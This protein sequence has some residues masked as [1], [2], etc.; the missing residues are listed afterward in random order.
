MY[1][2]REAK[3]RRDYIA[4]PESKNLTYLTFW[5]AQ[6]KEFR[7]LAFHFLVLK[8]KENKKE[9]LQIFLK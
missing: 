9:T 3:E 1:I 2:S 6:N 4:W 7:G 8:D 5:K